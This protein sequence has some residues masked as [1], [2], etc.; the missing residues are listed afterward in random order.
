MAEHPSPGELYEQADGD[1]ERYREL[2][3]EHGYLIPLK[4]GEKPEPL[5]CG[6]PGNEPEEADDGR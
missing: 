6:W 2:M 4:P 3:F 5:P 1:R